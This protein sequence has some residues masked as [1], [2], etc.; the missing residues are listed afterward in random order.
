M[1][2]KPRDLICLRRIFAK[3]SDNSPK[4]A[5]G[6]NDLRVHKNNYRLAKRYKRHK[7]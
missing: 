3:C 6:I 1:R 4:R 7:K 2:R 5:P